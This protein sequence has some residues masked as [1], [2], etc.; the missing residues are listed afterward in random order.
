VVQLPENG[1]GKRRSRVSLQIDPIHLNTDQTLDGAA[2]M[3]LSR[4]CA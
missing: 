4:Y 2:L 3:I 1:H